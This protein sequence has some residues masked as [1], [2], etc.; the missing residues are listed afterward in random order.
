MLTIIK[1][2]ITKAMRQKIGFVNDIFDIHYSLNI[3]STARENKTNITKTGEIYTNQ[4]PH[5][6]L[7]T[8]PLHEFQITSINSLLAVI[9]FVLVALSLHLYPFPCKLK[10]H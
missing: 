3:I 4:S 9:L 2:F 8:E 7:Q 10:A 6:L 1:D 5:L